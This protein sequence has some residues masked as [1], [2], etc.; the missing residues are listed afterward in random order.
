MDE[1]T[2]RVLEFNKILAIPAAWAITEPGRSEVL[3]TRPLGG[4]DQV[5]KRIDAVSEFKRLISG[6]R[7]TG[8]EHFHELS[9]LFQRLRPADSVLE[10]GELRSFLPLF[11][12]AGSLSALGNDPSFP[13][14]GLL[15]S[16]LSDHQ[17]AA[18]AIEGAID[19]EGKVR[20]GASAE[21][22]RIRLGI[23]QCESRIRTLLE[24]ILHQKDL[25]SHIQDFYL[26]ERNSRWVIPVKRD[27]KGGVPGIV[28]DISNTGET[29][30]VEPYSTQ[31]LGNELESLRA[32]EKLE[33][34][35]ILRSL[36]AILRDSLPV[37][38][39]DYRTIAAADALQATASFSTQMGMSPPE[40]NEGGFI[41]IA[42][43]RHPLLWKTLR[44]VKGEEGVVPLDLEVGR[45]HSCVVITGSNAGG[46]TVALKT[47]GVLTLMALSGMHTP[48]GSGT[49]FPFLGGLLADIGDDQSIELNLSTFSAH[50]RRISE[51]VRLSSPRTLIL[52]DEL[53]TGTDPDQGGALSCAVLRRIMK[54]GALALIST[55]LGRLKAFAHNE[56]GM[57]NCAMEMREVTVQGAS[58]FVPTYR[59]IVGEPGM[60]HT[61][62]IAGSLGLD[63]DIIRE[64]RE[65]ITEGGAAIESLLSELREKTGELE[66]RLKETERLREEARQVHSRLR[67]EL[68]EMEGAKKTVLSKA[69]REAREIVRKAKTEAAEIIRQLRKSSPEKRTEAL[70]ALEMMERDI[71]TAER[72]HEP[73][74]ASPLS[75]VREGQYVTVT[76][77]GSR[78]L[79]SS[80]NEK[81][82]KCTVLIDGKEVIVPF[83]ELADA[84]APTPQPEASAGKDRTSPVQPNLRARE[85]VED[86]LNLIGQ[87]VDPALSQ[88]ERYLNDAALA[89][90]RQVRIIHGYGTG[91][92]AR[93]VREFVQDHPLVESSR[94]GTEEEGGE[95]VTVVFL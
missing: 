31:H 93:A 5:R 69:L 57:I 36:S 66:S 18:A 88:I 60:S 27:S 90:L 59:L 94:G 63:E 68:A 51:I 50:I 43:G 12:S 33:T 35:R 54:S 7:H 62:E 30:Y 40:I 55:H 87:R 14:I 70:P 71:R 78:G 95:A 23:K 45:G 15:V 84:S 89:G 56:Q 83:S 77:L 65:F 26:A 17:V 41:R 48:S 61:L 24:G 4:P 72:L 16:G 85:G 49:S 92:L 82:R 80:V 44:Q 86:Q 76:A 9:P 39:N 46:K 73:E 2:L 13:L 64:A 28:H 20:D 53:G 10:P 75:H 79:V 25:A 47:V 81:S 8:I 22:S 29:V 34:Y 74:R 11:N 91:T 38:E 21:L 42:A 67:D 3:R 52:I 19:R 32:E 58:A 6:G 1:H 37:I